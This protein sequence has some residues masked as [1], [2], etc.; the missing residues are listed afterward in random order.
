[1]N[2]NFEHARELMVKNQLRPNKIKEKAILN[3]F[4]TIPKEDFVPDKIK[5]FVI[6]LGLS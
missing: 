5:I 4:Q 1:M 6:L 2:L 3:L